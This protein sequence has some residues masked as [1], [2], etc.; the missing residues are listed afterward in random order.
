MSA[1][2]RGLS[3]HDTAIK[4]DA[5]LA[6]SSESCHVVTYEYNRSATAADLPEFVKALLLKLGVTD[7]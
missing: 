5:T 3:D 4:H 2:F 7:G 1:P 6:R